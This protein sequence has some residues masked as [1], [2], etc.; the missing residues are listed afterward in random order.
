MQQP[1][2]I[3]INPNCHQGRGFKRWKSIREDVLSQLPDAKEIVTEKASDLDNYISHLLTENEKA[4]IISAGGDGSLH[5][6]SNIILRAGQ[7]NKFTIG[8]IGLGS[9]NDFLK[10]FQSFIRKI[11]VRINIA[12]PSL[13]HDAG[14]VKYIDEN[15]FENEKFFVIN[16]SFGATAEG[17]WNFNNPGF[18][19]KWLKKT[20]SNAA[21]SF[22]ALTTILKYQNKHVTI[23]YN[24]T[25][26]QTAISNIN[27]LKIPYVSGSLYYKQNILPDDGRLGLNICMNMKTTELFQ[28]LL[29]LEK[30]RFD[31]NDKKVST[32]TNN[33]QL[34]SATP[35][36]FECDGETEKSTKVEISIIPK[37][38][39]LLCV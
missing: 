14:R 11:P 36:V 2:F 38:I 17:N 33:F 9:S 34:V 30:G 26:M 20:S 27:I 10:P 23:R 13:F 1:V 15:S 29:H 22:T 37:A 7:A 31:Q 32:Y 16:A 39:R 18:V 25:E 6:L 12:K 24:G 28:T 35:I 21:I 4:C 3:I 8:A 5:Q 19:L